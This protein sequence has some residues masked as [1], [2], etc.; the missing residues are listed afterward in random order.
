MATP[1]V[2]IGAGGFGREVV[3]IVDAMGRSLHPSPA[4]CTYEIIGFLDDGDPDRGLLI[5]LGLAHL[6]DSRDTASLP[7]RTEYVV[8]IADPK[9]RLRIDGLCSDRGMNA[10]TLIH[11]TA[12]LGRLNRLAPGVIVCANAN[13]TTNVSL[14]RHSHM[15]VG[16]S[17]GHDVS[18]GNYATVL[19]G[20]T[21]SGS[22]T[23]GSRATI[24]AASVILQG[25]SI[26]DDA[27]V[28]AGAA[29]VRDVPA[30]VVVAGVPARPLGGTNSS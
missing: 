17:V 5:E 30:Q 23:V 29:V 26:G 2:I 28:G 3:D 9:S 1:L 24:G 15:H 21:V 19:P 8:A 12:T 7:E 4:G 10:A 20:S 13:L 16:S 27:V 18:I 25:L 11:P 14:G 6:G 22:V